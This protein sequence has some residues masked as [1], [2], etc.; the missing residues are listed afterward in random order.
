MPYVLCWG[1]INRGQVSDV[2]RL[3]ACPTA[4][5]GA[6]ARHHPRPAGVFSHHKGASK[7]GVVTLVVS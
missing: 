1:K 3:R 4:L 2:A 7:V 5:E 6:R